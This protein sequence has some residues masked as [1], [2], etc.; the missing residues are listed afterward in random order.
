MMLDILKK[1]K[2]RFNFQIKNFCIMGNHIHLLIKP[3][4]NENLSRIMQWI[5]SV[6]AV[7]F[8][9]VKGFRGHVWY[10]RFKSKIIASFQQFINTFQYIQNNPVLAG[11]VET[12]LD[13]KYSGDWH[14]RAQS[15]DFIDEPDLSLL[16]GT[17]MNTNELIYLPP[18]ER[19]R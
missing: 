2:K 1:A 11:L 19:Y 4:K 5:L 9:S 17:Q 3:A 16:L 15:Y 6:F 13:Y 14:I 12:H 8:N 18:P 7:R 10:D